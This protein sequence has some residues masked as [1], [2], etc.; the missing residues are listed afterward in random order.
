MSTCAARPRRRAHWWICCDRAQPSSVQSRRGRDFVEIVDGRARRPHL[1]RRGTAAGS[2][3]PACPGDQLV[4]LDDVGDQRD[5]RQVLG[6]VQHPARPGRGAWRGTAASTSQNRD[7][8]RRGVDDEADVSVSALDHDAACVR[9]VVPLRQ[10]ARSPGPPGSR[11]G[12]THQAVSS[13]PARSCSPVSGENSRTPDACCHSTRAARGLAGR[14]RT[15]FG[16]RPRRD[17]QQ[18][19]QGASRLERDV[20]VGDRA[21]RGSGPA[22]SVT[23]APG[24]CESV[25]GVGAQPQAQ[26][27]ERR[28]RRRGGCWQG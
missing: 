11:S 28:A 4:E 16:G 13:G 22:T 6:K 12:W 5:R 10:R 2:A 21:P 7:P 18:R 14:R 24:R 17:D 20:D 26:R 19:A 27:L 8:Q 1:R 25:E 23:P 3:P 9:A 15:S